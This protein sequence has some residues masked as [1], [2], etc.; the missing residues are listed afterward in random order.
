MQRHYDRIGKA[1][2]TFKIRKMV[3]ELTEFGPLIANPGSDPDKDKSILANGLAGLQCGC[4][5]GSDKACHDSLTIP[6]DTTLEGGCLSFQGEL[7]PIVM[8]PKAPT[9]KVQALNTTLGQGVNKYEGGIKSYGVTLNEDGSCTINHIGH[10][11]F[12]GFQPAEGDLLPA[13]RNCEYIKCRT[14][15]L[16]VVPGTAAQIIQVKDV[17]GNVIGEVEVDAS[18]LTQED[19]TDENAA[20]LADAING[21]LTSVCKPAE[22]ICAN[23]AFVLHVFVEQGNLPVVKGEGKTTDAPLAYCDPGPKGCEGMFISSAEDSESEKAKK[24]AKAVKATADKAVKALE[25]IFAKNQKAKEKS[26]A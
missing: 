18:G 8:N 13:T 11:T 24:A 7:F 21:T 9:D 26:D 12:D 20:L 4:P 23:A 1:Y 19:L 15:Q 14:F 25:S 3:K 2:K 22:V 10:G 17:D 5:T 6:A 16:I